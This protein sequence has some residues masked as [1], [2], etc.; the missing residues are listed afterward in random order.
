VEVTPHGQPASKP[1]FCWTPS[2]DEHYVVWACQIYLREWIMIIIMLV[3]RAMIPPITK[4]YTPNRLMA[5]RLL[6]PLIFALHVSNGL[7]THFTVSWRSKFQIHVVFSFAYTVPINLS[8]SEVLYNILWGLVI[9][10]PKPNL[11]NQPFS[12]VC[13]CL[14]N[15][16]A[17]NLHIWRPSPPSAT[18]RT[19]EL[20][21]WSS[22]NDIIARL[23]PVHLQL[24]ARGHLPTTPLEQLCA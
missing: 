24:I 17:V 14:F 20:W 12:A 22:R 2:T 18:C 11:D 10:T 7:V 8:K 15:I 6:C 21:L 16:F 3:Q 5:K 1:I 9:P 13:D 4:M 19:Y 23:T